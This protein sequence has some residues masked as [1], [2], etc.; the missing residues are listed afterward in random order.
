MCS[1][2]L[3]TT[4]TKC[5]NITRRRSRRGRHCL[6]S[7]KCLVSVPNARTQNYSDLQNGLSLAIDL[8]AH[9]EKV[10][11]AV[12]LQAELGYGV[13]SIFRV[14]QDSLALQPAARV[15]VLLGVGAADENGVASGK[16][17]RVDPIV[18]LRRQVE[19]NIPGR[20]AIFFFLRAM[21]VAGA[22][23]R[24]SQFQK[25][26]ELLREQLEV[27]GRIFLGDD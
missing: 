4:V 25:W 11:V 1:L 2:P 22:L 24:G 17:A 8:L 7:W 15:T 16:R 23:T 12:L 5:W 20:S 14:F 6:R 18:K 10:D 19:E 3:T 26:C 13:F 27:L 21:A 9:A